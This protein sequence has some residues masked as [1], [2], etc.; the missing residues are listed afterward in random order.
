MHRRAGAGCDRRPVAGSGTGDRLRRRQ[1]AWTPEAGPGVEVRL[2]DRQLAS[3]T[4]NAEAMTATSYDAVVVGS[5]PNGLTAAVTL[6]RAGLGVL[7]V[8]AAETPGGGLRSEESTLP[9]YIHDTC[10]TVHTVAAASPFLRTLPLHEYGLEWVHAPTPVAHPLGNGTAIALSRSIEET[11]DA[12]GWDDGAAYRSL[13]EPFVRRWQDLLVDLLAPIRPPR[14][15][16]LFARFGRLAIHSVVSLAQRCFEG[17]RARALLAGLAGHALLPLE[18]R[19]TAAFALVLSILGHAVGW[20]VVR[21]G[22]QRLADAL[23]AYL[24][25]LGGEVRT[26]WL[27]RSLDELPPA[28]LVLLDLDPK[29]VARITGDRL[30]RRYRNRLEHFRFGPGTFKID[31]ALSDPIPWTAPECVRAGT[32]HVGGSMAE[33]RIAKRATEL[34]EHPRRPLLLVVQ[35]TRFDPTRAPAGRH[36]GYALCHVPAGSDRD[37][38][39]AVEAQVERFAPGF[40]ETILARTHLTARD[41]E[42]LNPNL[43]D[44]DINGGVADLRQIAARPIISMNPYATPVP[45]LY[46]CS[47]STPPGGGGH[48][49]CGYHAARAALRDLGRMAE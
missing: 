44:G 18:S 28:S 27:V 24:R 2:W 43:V 26:E 15:P 16:L 45:G 33:I 22:S 4:W 6:A 34:G 30:P 21:G 35:A 47:A 20:P 1:L 41:L 42:R 12:L 29:Q 25:T 36:T 8:E 11:A 5:G 32:V 49:M 37:M 14:H 31:W 48:G 10:A 19:P 13:V 39:A 9:G 17:E 7:V 46:I 38:T 23:V 3:A 40:R